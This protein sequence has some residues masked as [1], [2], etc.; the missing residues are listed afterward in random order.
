MHTPY[1]I[2]NYWFLGSLSTHWALYVIGL[3]GR[4]EHLLLVVKHVI[5]NCGSDPE[6]WILDLFNKKKL[7]LQAPGLNFLG[8]KT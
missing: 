5:V 8:L 4:P 1:K 3:D 6:K 2:Q 7:R